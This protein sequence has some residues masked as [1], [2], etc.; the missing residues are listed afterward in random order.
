MIE[1]KLVT[2]EELLRM[3]GQPWLELV[4]G[5]LH[6]VS[7]V[8]RPHGKFSARLAGL[9][10]LFV[11]DRGLG[12]VHVETGFV[13]QRN[14][15][16]VRAPDVAYVSAERLVGQSEDGFLEGAPDL[17]VEFVSPS[18]TAHEVQAKVELYLAAGARLVSLFYVHQQSVMVHRPDGT[19]QLVR[20][21]GVLDGE[22]VLP[23]FQLS[24]A[25]FFVATRRRGRA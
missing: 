11:D 20:R 4:K 17:A 15:D 5:E 18:E 16:T 14:P 10:S 9:L 2:A 1:T 12:E 19:A 7:P 8:A 13:L 25:E 22:D 24:L 6:P 23:G 21:D 3:P